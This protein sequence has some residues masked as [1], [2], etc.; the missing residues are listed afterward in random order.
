MFS[1]GMQ[2]GD[3]WE[4]IFSVKGDTFTAELKSQHAVEKRENLRTSVGEFDSLRISQGASIIAV[5]TGGTHRGNESSSYWVG[6]IQGVQIM[7]RRKYRNSFG[8]S[9]DIELES[10]ELVQR[11]VVAS[12]NS[13]E[14]SVVRS[15]Q[16]EVSHTVPN[17]DGEFTIAISTG[18]DTASLKVNDEELGGRADGKYEIRRLARV[19]QL[20]EFNVVATAVN[21]QTA[22]QA[23]KVSRPLAQ[24]APKFAAL[25]P[26][27]VRSRLNPNAV[28][29]II[30]IQNYK[31]VPRADFASNDAKLFYDY[32]IRALGIQPENIKILL[33]EQA[34]DVEVYKAFQSWLPAKVK[35]Q[36]TDVYVF[37]SGHGLPSDDGRSLYILPHGVDKDLVQRTAIP[38]QEIVSLLQAAKPRHVTMFMDACYSGQI[39]TG[40]TLLA[41]ARPITVKAKDISYPPAFTVLSA[42]AP[43]QIASSSPDLKHGI[44]SYF[45]MKG[46][47][48]EADLNSDGKIS[49]AEME[50]FLSDNV[51]RLAMSLSR[52]Q[53]PQ[54]MGDSS[55]ILIIR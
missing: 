4:N 44:F 25:D 47:E 11:P 50:S 36:V 21:G 55:R 39:R 49:V 37:Y 1:L 45:L 12:I 32:A 31:R 18:T 7:L 2:I 48:G 19:G 26:S 28:A 5:A 10:V 20:T 15:I 27:K 42:S 23:V 40:D 51:S 9:S 3:K 38:K 13:F 16:L 17:V 29:I 41:N 54:V 30:G 46:L 22:N 53:E 52:K 33:D 43:D 24:N 35:R 34:D 6:E 8:E 14:K